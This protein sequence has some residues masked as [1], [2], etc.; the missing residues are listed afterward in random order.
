MKSCSSRVLAGVATLLLSALFARPAPAAEIVDVTPWREILKAHVTAQGGVDYRGLVQDLPKLERFVQSY[1]QAQPAGASDTAKKAAYLNL[2]NATMILHLLRYHRDASRTP[3]SP[4]F[5]TTHIN[6]ISTP[7]GNIWNGSY[8]VVL[9]GVE[10]NLDDIEHGLL[11]R[12]KRPHLDAFKVSELDPRIHAAANCAAYSCPRLREVPFESTTVDTMLDA[13]M[14]EFLSSDEQFH[15][16]DEDTMKANTIVRWYYGDFDSYGK[17]IKM[18]GAG[19]YLATFVEDKSPDAAW[20]RAHWK[21][22]FNDRSS[23]TL[24]VTSAFQFDYDWRVNDV[25]HKGPAKP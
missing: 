13:N 19:D 10:V 23:F 4:E 3:S 17:H 15:R 16:I 22:T 6:S 18:A 14:R 7:G 5:L 1:A 20:K 9:A 2:Y 25:R 8:K 24:L 12:D 11:R 21:Q